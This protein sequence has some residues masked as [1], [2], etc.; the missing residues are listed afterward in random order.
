MK[1]GSLN[2]ARS[3]TREDNYTKV[4]FLIIP[5]K[6]SFDDFIVIRQFI[7]GNTAKVI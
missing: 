7:D 3:L 6:R 1:G 4:E 2:R 5:A